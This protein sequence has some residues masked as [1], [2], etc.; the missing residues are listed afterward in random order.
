[1]Q[2]INVGDICISVFE[3]YDETRKKMSYKTRPV[4]II[5]K[6]DDD[7]LTVLPISTIRKKRYVNRKYD[8]FIDS[9]LHAELGLNKDCYIRTNKQ[10][11]VHRQLITKVISSL[12]HHD[13]AMFYDALMRT[14]SYSTRII[15]DGL[16]Y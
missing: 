2:N 7:D 11:Y 1:M 15:S 10:S 4:L 6:P 9:N 3:F 13:P 5:G 12:K 14:R 8:I 16:N